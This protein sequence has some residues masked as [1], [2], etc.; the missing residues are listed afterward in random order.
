[1]S[2]LITVDKRA[3]F[4]VHTCCHGYI[5]IWVWTTKFDTATQPFLEVDTATGA[6]LKFLVT[7]RQGSVDNNG[8]PMFN[9]LRT[10]TTSE[11]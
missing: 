9:P 4:P 7:W 10:R 1:M 2:I 6:F 11:N 8:R 3:A 5:I